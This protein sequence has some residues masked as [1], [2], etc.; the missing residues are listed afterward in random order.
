MLKFNTGSCPFLETA[1]DII[2]MRKEE[3]GRAPKGLL[4]LPT[5]FTLVSNRTS[6]RTRAWKRCWITLKKKAFPTRSFWEG[7]EC[8]SPISSPSSCLTASSDSSFSS[9]LPPPAMSHPPALALGKGWDSPALRM[10]QI[11]SQVAFAFLM[12]CQPVSN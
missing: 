6:G 7:M 10:Q 1:F 11:I 8:A 9:S 12:C 4:C 5:M 2:T 3:Q